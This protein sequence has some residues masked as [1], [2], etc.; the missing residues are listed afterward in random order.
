M[1]C[2]HSLAV[3]DLSSHVVVR[4]TVIVPSNLRSHKGL[5]DRLSMNL[6]GNWKSTGSI[7]RQVCSQEK[8]TKAQDKKAFQ[9]LTMFS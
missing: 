4:H 7:H 3:F 5:D 6:K 2:Q 9:M 1:H 8:G